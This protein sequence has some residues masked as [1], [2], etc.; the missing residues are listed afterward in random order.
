M[1]RGL[2]FTTRAGPHHSTMTPPPPPPSMALAAAMA[3]MKRKTTPPVS[4]KVQKPVEQP[5]VHSAP[6]VSLQPLA[7]KP[8]QRAV[9]APAEAPTLSG[10]C[11]PLDV[12]EEPPHSSNNPTVPAKSLFTKISHFLITFCKSFRRKA[13][14]LTEDVAKA[15]RRAFRQL[16]GSGK[17]KP[18]AVTEEVTV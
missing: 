12:P 6:T 8:P 16:V 10:S 15:T 1:T 13:A 9:S 5:R 4:P 2:S 18:A 3:A 11:P 7:P 14:A 17:A